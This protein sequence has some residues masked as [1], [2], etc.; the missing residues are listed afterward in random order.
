M[1]VNVRAM[2]SRAGIP[3]IL[4]ALFFLIVVSGCVSDTASETGILSF[5]SSPS[6]AEVYLDNQYRGSTPSTLENVATG[7]H[8]LE[9]R[10]T[11]YKSWS[12]TISVPQGRSHYYAALTPVETPGGASVTE[13]IAPGPAAS[14]SVTAK[15]SKDNMIIGES[16]LFSGTASNTDAVL[17]TVFG[18]GKYTNGVSLVRQTINPQ[19]EWSTTW[20]PGT[21]LMGGTYTIV[22]QDSHKTTSARREFTV[23]GGGRVSI[24]PNTYA[25]VKGQTV[26]FSGQCT[27]GAKNIYL[28]LFGPEQFTSGVAFPE[29]PVSADQT[30]SF[31]YKLDSTMPTGQYT[32]YIYDSPKTASSSTQFTIGYAG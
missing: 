1:T 27:T 19:G 30:W 29:L 23:I 18:P 4:A 28:V 5:S 21:S 20:N 16:N 24:T 11:G 14:A 10:L 3:G 22:A 25:A 8:S 12:S 15:V 6:G 31:K 26:T 9:F 32:M 13:T 17:L 2:I 7:S